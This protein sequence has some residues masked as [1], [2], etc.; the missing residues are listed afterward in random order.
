[1]HLHDVL[2]SNNNKQ[3]SYQNQRSRIIYEMEIKTRN[4]FEEAS[5]HGLR[6]AR[7]YFLSW[8]YLKFCFQTWAVIHM[9]SSLVLKFSFH[10]IVL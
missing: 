4:G 8:F 5:F 7:F 6:L 2:K 3:Q 9:H 1:M 10:I